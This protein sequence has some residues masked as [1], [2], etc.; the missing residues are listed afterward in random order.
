MEGDA[1][2]PSAP[3]PE[4]A[5]SNLVPAADDAGVPIDDKQQDVGVSDAHTGKGTAKPQIAADVKQEAPPP[6][7][8]QKQQREGAEAD[9]PQ[10]S[11]EMR[12][13]KKKKEKKRKEGKD[14]SDKAHSLKESK[15]KSVKPESTP[16][17]ATLESLGHSISLDMDNLSETGQKPAG[18]Q[19]KQRR[20]QRR[21][22]QQQQQQRSLDNK[23]V[24]GSCGGVA[25]G[26]QRRARKAE[27]S[28]STTTAPGKRTSVSQ[29]S[30]TAD[31]CPTAVGYTN[32]EGVISQRCNKCNNVI[33]EFSDEEIGMCIVILRTYVHREP[34]MAAPL[35]PEMLKL[36]TR[37]TSYF[38]NAWQYERF[39]VR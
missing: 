16:R 8:Q 33:E 6:Q 22:A 31:R 26:V 4:N 5:T 30:V 15:K 23:S 35:M 12:P 7:Q 37:F 36:V 9:V 28:S 18:R 27:T 21:E 1:A 2:Q 24:S 32:D 10:V 25:A 39:V 17:Q 29:A 13:K 20:Q 11:C 34:G 38:P 3:A 14:T 19:F